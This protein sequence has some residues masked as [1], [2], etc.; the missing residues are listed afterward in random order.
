MPKDW[1]E[2]RVPLAASALTSPIN[3]LDLF[4]AYQAVRAKVG[5]GADERA[6]AAAFAL[7]AVV[8]HGE[9]LAAGSGTEGPCAQRDRR[10]VL[11]SRPTALPLPP[12]RRIDVQLGA[13]R[14]AA[15][16]LQLGV[17]LETWDH[18]RRQLLRR[19]AASAVRRSLAISVPD[20]RPARLL[21]EAGGGAHHAAAGPDAVCVESH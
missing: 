16:G 18:S 8:P 11:C 5:R 19:A 17:D 3:T 21:L 10:L 6:L 20:Q 13:V 4:F 12:A 15:D 2:L 9:P 1:T 14:A 7:L